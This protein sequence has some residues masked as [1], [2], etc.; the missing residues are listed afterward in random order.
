MRNF[1][2]VDIL[3]LYQVAEA[4]QA[5]EATALHLAQAV[6]DSALTVE[7]ASVR[8]CWSDRHYTC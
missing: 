4:A 5:T 2:L 6:E 1:P 7:P 8:R 3:T